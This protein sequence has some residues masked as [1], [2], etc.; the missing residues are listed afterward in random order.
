MRKD[1]KITINTLQKIIN[2]IVE[3]N[4]V[5]NDFPHILK[6]NENSLNNSTDKVNILNLYFVNIGKT[7]CL[8][9]GNNLNFLSCSLTKVLIVC[10]FLYSRK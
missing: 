10:L 8:K 5:D 3:K 1:C 6:L 9:S 2:D 7:T 4:K